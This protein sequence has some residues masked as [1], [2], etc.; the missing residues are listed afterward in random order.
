[1]LGSINTDYKG[2][3]IKLL[4]IHN[5]HIPTRMLYIDDCDDDGDDSNAELKLHVCSK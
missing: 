3:Y 2:I 1:M 5:R 4:F